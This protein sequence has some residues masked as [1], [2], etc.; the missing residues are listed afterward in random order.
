MRALVAGSGTFSRFSADAGR[1]PE[2][3]PMLLGIVFIVFGPFP[4]DAKLVS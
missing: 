1:V 4:P 2:S 3:K